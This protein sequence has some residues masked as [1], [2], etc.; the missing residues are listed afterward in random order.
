MLEVRDV[1]KSF[2]PLRALDSVNATFKPGEIHA[3]LGEN[4]AGKSTLMHVMAGFLRPDRGTVLLNGKPLPTGSPFECRR[5]GIG[6]VHQHFTLV[7]N[8]TVAENLAL[9]QMESLGGRIDPDEASQ[10]AVGLADSLGWHLELDARVADLPVGTQQRIEIVK[11]LAIDAEVLI[12][13][14]PTAVL[15]PEEVEDLFRVL[16]MLRGG[17]K[18]VVLIAHKLSEVMAISD[19]VTVLRKGRWIANSETK[20]VTLRQLAEWMVGELPPAIDKAAP[21]LLEAR[22][23]ATA[24]FV[25][26]DRGELAVDGVDFQIAKGEIV[27]FGGVDG[28]GQVELAEALAGL[29]EADGIT[30]EGDW[31]D[32]HPAYIPQDRQSD[33]L[34]MGMSIQDNLLIGGLTNPALAS[35]PFLKVSAVQEW[36]KGL[37]QAF[38]IKVESARDSVS[39]L[40][41]GNQQKVVVSRT[42]DRQ[43]EFL[44]VVN[45]TRGL[46]I[47]AADYVQT[48]ILKARDRGAAV[49]LFSTDLDELNLL[50]DRTYF[51]S[52]GKLVEGSD[53]TAL[54]GGE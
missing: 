23:L 5:Q 25:R 4:G 34:A 24:V 17:G 54:V 33:G 28:N 6:M 29:R 10:K 8:F 3:V 43:P 37:I 36:A 1:S 51:M 35:G 48:Q 20:K 16:R 32:C 7:P 47:R 19:R 14:E 12:F 38:E 42:L 30:F 50:A 45:P 53:A 40:S 18:T 22:V 31:T 52:R 41:G 39:S 44:V 13:D 27:G 46:D 49:A 26:G 15:T 11:A 2:G 21:N 9:A